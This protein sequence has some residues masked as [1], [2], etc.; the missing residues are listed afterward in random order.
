MRGIFVGCD[1]NSPA[2]MVYYPSNRKILKHRLVEFTSRINK[3]MLDAEDDD[4]VVQS[5]R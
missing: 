5:K 1:K 4:L 3:E 2:Y